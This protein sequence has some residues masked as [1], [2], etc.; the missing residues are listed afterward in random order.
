MAHAID[1]DCTLTDDDSVAHEFQDWGKRQIPTT[2]G[3]IR[4][5]WAKPR[6]LQHCL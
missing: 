3:D 2:M 4:K 5:N 1:D 6:G